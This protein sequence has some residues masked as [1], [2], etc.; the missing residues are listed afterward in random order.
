MIS[1][2]TVCYNAESSIAETIESILYHSDK[3]Y[4]HIIIDGASNDK[5]L[6][7]IK[8]YQREYEKNKIKLLLVSEPDRGI[9]DAMN[10]G[11]KLATNDWLLYVNSGDH[12][13]EKIDETILKID[14]INCFGFYYYYMLNNEKYR[15]SFEPLFKKYDLP[16]CH[17]AMFFPK[18]NIYYDVKFRYCA[19]YDYYSQYIKSGFGVNFVK[20][21]IIEYSRGGVSERLLLRT[22]KEKLLINVKIYKKLKT[23]FY[24]MAIYLKELFMFFIKKIIPSKYILKRRLNNGYTIFKD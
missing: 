19:D 22:L 13:I 7:I 14:K 23:L 1:I 8:S 11:I 16:T 20:T 17:N 10:K 2:I 18:K 6:S 9:Y 4:E 21:K 12:V 3:G 24:L 15:K 5:T